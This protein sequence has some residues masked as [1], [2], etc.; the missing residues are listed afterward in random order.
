MMLDVL[1]TEDDDTVMPLLPS[2]LELLAFEPL[3]APAPLL[4]VPSSS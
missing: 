2:P 4:D 1:D 3:A